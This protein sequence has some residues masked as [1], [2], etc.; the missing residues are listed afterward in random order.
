MVNILIVTQGRLADELLDAAQRIA[1]TSE[2]LTAL[3]LDWDYDVETSAERIREAV[4]ALA[5][6]EGLLILTDVFGGTP[7]NLATRHF[8]PGHVE[9]LAG[10]NLPI[11]IRLACMGSADRK[12]TEL[13]EWI[14]RKGRRSICLGGLPEKPRQLC[15]PAA[16]VP[17]RD[18]G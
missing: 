3:S 12:V 8:R 17:L 10:V 1:G 11:V 5:T 15:R 16:A 9:I 4:E 2:R 14:E 7:Y 13:A 18:D 6:G